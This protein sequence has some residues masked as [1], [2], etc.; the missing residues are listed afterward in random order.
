VVA[1]GF[2]VLESFESPEVA[3]SGI[4][5]PGVGEKSLGGH[6]VL[7]VGYDLGQT[8]SIRPAN[9]PP[10]FLIQNSWGAGWGLSGFFWMVKDVFDAIDTDL[11]IAHSGHPW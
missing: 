3:S 5:N 4:Y 6:E 10:A 2:T 1:V 11:K 8:P 7:C 9:C